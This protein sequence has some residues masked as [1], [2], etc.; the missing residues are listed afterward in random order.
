VSKGT[1]YEAEE[2]FDVQEDLFHPQGS[3]YFDLLMCLENMV[4]SQ[5]HKTRSYFTINDTFGI[6]TAEG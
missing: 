6:V 4:M 3:T 5:S 1:D 2:S